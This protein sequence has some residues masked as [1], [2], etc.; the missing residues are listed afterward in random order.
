MTLT[1][2]TLAALS[3]YTESWACTRVRGLPSRLLPTKGRPRRVYRVED[4]IARLEGATVDYSE[5]IAKIRALVPEG[6]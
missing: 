6:V 3:G 1:T 2:K 5:L 4:V